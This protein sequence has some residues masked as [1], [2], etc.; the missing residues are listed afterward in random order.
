M[1]NDMIVSY[2]NEIKLRQSTRKRGAKCKITHRIHISTT[3]IKVISQCITNHIF[4]SNAN[5]EQRTIQLVHFSIKSYHNIV[6]HEGINQR[7]VQRS[8]RGQETIS[9][10]SCTRSTQIHIEVQNLKKDNW[11]HL[12]Q[13][14]QIKE[15]Y[16]LCIVHIS[17]LTPFPF[18]RNGGKKNE[19]KVTMYTN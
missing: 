9:F 8:T 6:T 11:S 1:R 19:L 12:C 14:L 5:S 13:V 18:S 4:I 2:K 7:K 15:K 17:F 16:I 10:F 3:S